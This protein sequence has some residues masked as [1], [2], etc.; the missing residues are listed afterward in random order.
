MTQIRRLL[1]KI[2]VFPSEGPA[3]VFYNG[4]LILSALAGTIITSYRLTFRLH[5]F[6]A[7]YW[8]ITI[9]YIVDIPYTFNQSVKKGLKIFSDRRS[10]ATPVSPRLVRR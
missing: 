8:I 1:G 2:P 5:D 7:I 10:I 6:D 9:I 3:K 4:F